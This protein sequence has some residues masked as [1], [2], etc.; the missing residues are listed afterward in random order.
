MFV[1]GLAAIP[2]YIKHICAG[3]CFLRHSG[4]RSRH[5]K[6]AGALSVASFHFDRP[7]NGGRETARRKG[8]TGW[9]KNREGSSNRIR[10]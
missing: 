4:K 10:E 8:N 6:K 5:H 2:C 3:Q 1:S 7:V 9:K